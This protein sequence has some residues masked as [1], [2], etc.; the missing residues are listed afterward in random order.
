MMSGLLRYQIFLGYGA[1]FLAVW[2]YAL[3]KQQDDARS[4]MVELAPVWAVLVLGVYAASSLV[5][6]VLTFKDCPE[7]AKELEQQVSEAKAEMR[8]RGIQ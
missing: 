5:Y 2:F 6:G 7:A 8:K 3:S 4:L 1:L